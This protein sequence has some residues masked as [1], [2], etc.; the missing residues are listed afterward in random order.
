MSVGATEPAVTLSGRVLREPELPSSLVALVERSVRRQPR[1]VA[2]RWSDPSTSRW[3]SL[4]YAELWDRILAVSLGLKRLGVGPGDRVLVFS[5]SRPEWGIAD[6]AILALG[7]VS[8]PIFSGEGRLRVRAIVRRIGARV[9]FAEGSAEVGLLRDAGMDTGA[10]HLVVFDPV[11]AGAD[12][13]A[14]E[15]LVEAGAAAAAAEASDWAERALA[16]KPDAVATVVHALGRGGELVGA[17]LSHGNVLRNVAMAVPAL[18]LTER[19]VVLSVLPLSHMLERGTGL[20]VPLGIGATVAYAPPK[21][22]HLA[23]ALRAVRP[24]AMVAVPLLLDRLADGVRAEIRALGPRRRA[25]V[26]RSIRL[27]APRR[28]QRPARRRMIA[29]LARVT[30]LRGIRA[31]LGGRLR[32]IACGGSALR[33]ATGR[34]LTACGVPVVEG[35]GLTEAAPLVALNDLEAPRFGAVGRPLPGTEVRIDPARGEILVRGPQVMRGY[36]DDPA[37]TARALDADGWLRTGDIGHVDEGGNL[38]ITGRL[39]PLVVLA[40]GKKVARRAIEAALLTSPWFVEVSILGDGEAEL[41]AEITID[42]AGM[43]ADAP[44]DTAARERRVEQEVRLRLEGWARYERP[45]IISLR[46]S[47]GSEPSARMRRNSVTFNRPRNVR[48]G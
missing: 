48:T 39:K 24:T 16:I 18:R 25:L 35:Y 11:A 2:M 34:F 27:Q 1:A 33:P 40:T 20:Y 36:L 23:D 28:R 30:V 31:G 9:A 14:F 43:D 12:V 37:A 8:C 4:T 21:T 19:E 10:G 44:G 46:S 15:R 29:W 5:R 47:D 45:R 3:Q 42:G 7:A 38:V 13:I 41:R 17:I 22:R 32:F 26:L 6:L